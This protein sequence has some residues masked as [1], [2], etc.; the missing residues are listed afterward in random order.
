LIAAILEAAGE[1]VGLTSTAN[2]R[3]AGEEQ[4]NALKMTMPGRFFLQRMLR[5]MVTAG[6]RYAVIETSSQGIAQFRHLGIEYD[7]AVFTN[8]TPEHIEA[9]G[10]FENYKRASS[11]SSSTSR[12]TPASACRPRR[13][14]EDDRR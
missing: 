14:H 4:V 13:G 2:F 10:G 12:T 3:I 9:H 7:I 8:L 11:C 5:R 6:C 1:K